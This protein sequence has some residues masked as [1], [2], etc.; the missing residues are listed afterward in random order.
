MSSIRSSRISTFFSSLYLRL[1]SKKKW[2]FFLSAGLIILCA[3]RFY[4][5]NLDNSFAPLLPHNSHALENTA[6][7]L[8][9]NPGSRTILVEILWDAQTEPNIEL[10]Q[11][12]ASNIEKSVQDQI[13]TSQF[14]D[15][16]SPESLLALIPA[17]FDRK[18]KE[19]IEIKSTPEAIEASISRLKHN[20]SGAQG[21][22]PKAFIRADPLNYL[23]VL[24]L[25][26]TAYMPNI[27]QLGQSFT[28]GEQYLVS[29]NG[30]QLLMI[31]RPKSSMNDTNAAK[32]L[33]CSLQHGLDEQI[34]LSGAPISYMI[35]GGMRF[36]AEN[37]IVIEHDLRLTVSLSLVLIAL[38]FIIFV[39]S[40]G[41]VWLFL[42]PVVA[43]ILSGS[44]VSLI[45]PQAAGL[46][47][48]FGAAVLGLA[49]D[50]AVIV[51]FSLRK[52]HT[53][54]AAAVGAAARP[55]FFSAALCMASFL[56]LMFSGIPALK[57]MGF[58]AAF[59]LLSGLFIAIF[60]LP[61][62][63]GMDR[64]HLPVS[65]DA[66]EKN[67][68]TGLR[69]KLLPTLAAMILMLAIC[70]GGLIHIPFDSTVQNMGARTAELQKELQIIRSHWQWEEQEL[71]VSSGQSID[72]ALQNSVE[73]ASFLRRQNDQAKIFSL[74]T[75][76]PPQQEREQN[77]LRWQNFVKENKNIIDEQIYTASAI[78]G[79][80]KKAFLPFINWLQQKQ[81]SNSFELIKQAGL[82]DILWWMQAERNGRYFALSFSNSDMQYEYLP[83]EL[84]KNNFLLSPQAISSAINDALRTETRLLPLTGLACLLLLIICF[85]ARPIPILL[86]C[87]PPLSGL[88]TIILWLLA[89]GEPLTFA[90]A[91]AL[92][93]VI[94][95]GADYGIVMLHELSASLSIWAFRSVLVSGLTTLSGI[96]VLILAEHPVLHGIGKIT[97]LG[98]T[99]EMLVVL[100]LI[101]FLCKKPRKKG[102]N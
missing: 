33:I 68:F 101:P 57:Q 37:T 75:I 97:F 16:P 17:I 44:V 8:D 27:A 59:A 84:Q 54:K 13:L 30:K 81:S 3:Y 43:V 23:E 4:N 15:I 65:A 53:D 39:R 70:I 96:G 35:N 94:G 41:A 12:I 74:S 52:N 82:G 24:K 34:S 72:E 14:Q 47:L 102:A 5:L 95:L 36:T 86:A 6:Q 69:P 2:V 19:L 48:G 22:A 78:N 11:T 31:L 73:L 42:T 93:L 21:F 91:A 61:L 98:L 60:I 45:W 90:G 56:M 66:V 83:P 89:T 40:W 92:I 49:E 55:L 63:P 20:L 76:I 51:H 100:L 18:T 7:L 29:D 88:A 87:L 1:E 64:P 77:L 79:F 26:F 50:Y 32:E 10:L 71:W 62:C 80:N 58:F 28:A 9:L 67:K 99:G 38:V 46:A 25:R 85:K